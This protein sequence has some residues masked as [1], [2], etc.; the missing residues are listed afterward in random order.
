MKP[1]KKSKRARTTTYNK[2]YKVVTNGSFY[3]YWDEGLHY[4]KISKKDNKR[5][6][7]MFQ[8]RMYRTWKH[9]RK[10]QCKNGKGNI[11]ETP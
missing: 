5:K 3:R 2:E 8:V 11:K 1:Y 10:T 9:N 7:L 4:Y 6:L